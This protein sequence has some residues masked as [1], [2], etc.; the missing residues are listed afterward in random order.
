MSWH[1]GLTQSTQ[2]TDADSRSNC[3]DDIK[4]QTKLYTCSVGQKLLGV[5]R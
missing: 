1:P 5:R 2:V 3:T 4:E